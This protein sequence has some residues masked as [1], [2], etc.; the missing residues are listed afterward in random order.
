MVGSMPNLK[1][2]LHTSIVR[3]GRALSSIFHD[4]VSRSLHLWPRLAPI[5]LHSAINANHFPTSRRVD[6]VAGDRN[7]NTEA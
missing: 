3:G 2:P 6:K 5:A 7:R 4:H 1:L